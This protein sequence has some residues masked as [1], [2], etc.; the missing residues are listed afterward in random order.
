[1][2]CLVCFRASLFF[3]TLCF[4]TLIWSCIELNPFKL[5]EE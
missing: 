5:E 4:W 3:Q 1:V 2:V